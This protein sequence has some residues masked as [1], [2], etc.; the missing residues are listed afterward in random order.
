MT[1]LQLE[2]S[3]E[4]VTGHENNRD[5]K[6]RGDDQQRETGSITTILNNTNEMMSG[7]RVAPA[8]S[9]ASFKPKTQ[10]R[11]S[12]WPAN[13]SMASVDGLRI[14]R[15]VRSA[16]IRPAARGQLPAGASAG[17]ASMFTLYPMIV[18][19]QYLPVLSPR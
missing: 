15:P 7:P 2:R 19:S 10:P 5:S 8:W 11:P 6:E 12:L 4:K 16:T 13:D 14:A 9:N 18:T 17:T 3:R 1:C